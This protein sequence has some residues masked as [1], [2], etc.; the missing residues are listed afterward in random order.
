[1]AAMLRKEILPGAAETR[2]GGLRRFVGPIRLCGA[3]APGLALLMA[4]GIAESLAADQSPPA[5]HVHA[6]D[7]IEIAVAGIPE[8]R[9]RSSV[10]PDGAISFP[11]IGEVNVAGLTPAELRETL[12]GRFAL[13][14]YPARNN[15]GREVLVIV[16]ADQ[17]TAAI[18]EYRPVYVDGDV[19]KPGELTFRPEMT[20]RQAIALAGG[21]DIGARLLANPVLAAAEAKGEYETAC[22]E[23]AKADARVARL[24]GELKGSDSLDGFKP[25]TVAVSQAALAKIEEGEGKILQA[26]LTDYRR[27]REFLQTSI[28]QLGDRAAVLE[29]QQ[30]E[31][32]EGARADTEEL[33]RTIDMLNKG[34]V[35]NPR[36]LDARRALLLSQ[37]RALQVTDGVLLLKKQSTEAERQLQHLDDDRRT[38]LLKDLQEATTATDA[39]KIKRDAALEKLNLASTPRSRFSIDDG[40]QMEIRLVRDDQGGATKMTVGS[41]F[42]LEPGDVIEVAVKTR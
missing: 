24:R 21:V 20:V 38:E 16:K 37:T 35:T 23:L 19:A 12:R 18:V 2:R 34:N 5:Y 6:G 31:E 14:V 32:E 26:R 8:L 7:V 13:K 29:R 39:L 33:R 4:F 42:Q 40:S 27:E 36:V 1:M 15:D 41:D 28:S 25:E 22:L 9:A 10:Q 11:L 17:V 30:K 3:L